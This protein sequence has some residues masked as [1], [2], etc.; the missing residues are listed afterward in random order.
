MSS[1]TLENKL[2]ENEKLL[3]EGLLSLD[4]CTEVISNMKRNKSPGSDG[5]PSE[6]Y[7]TFWNEIGK[8][9]VDSLNESI[10]KGQLS[11]SQ[12][13]AIMSLVFKKGDRQL[14]KNW[15]P[16]SL[17]NSDYK[18]ATFALGNRLHKVLP[19]LINSDQTGYVKNR[20]IGCNI[21]LIEDIIDYINGTNKKGI[22]LFCDFEK[23]FDTV[24]INFLLKVLKNL[25]WTPI[26]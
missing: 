12:K 16:I 4:E 2:N 21:R 1:I 3:C 14:L 11:T 20:F 19:K 22:I 18:I 6:F 25:I 23:A 13:H 10:E 5:L 9:V 8:L 7:K 17:L 15:R 24:E 26:Y